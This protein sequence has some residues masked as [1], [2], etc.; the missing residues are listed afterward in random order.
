MYPQLGWR[1]INEFANEVIAKVRGKE[2]DD[3]KSK[4]L[5]T[6]VEFRELIK[7]I[8]YPKGYEKHFND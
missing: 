1:F 5:L 2:I 7:V 4:T 6:N 3:I 8:G